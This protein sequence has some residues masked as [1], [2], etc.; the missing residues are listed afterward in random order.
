MTA[1]LPRPRVTGRYT[2][3][4]HG[5]ELRIYRRTVGLM[6]PAELR[7]EGAAQAAAGDTDRADVCAAAL[8]RL[9]A[10]VV[11]APRCHG[12]G[13]TETEPGIYERTE[14]TDG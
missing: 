5:A 9:T 11:D 13:W 10:L 12:D 14:V 8:A 3:A 2:D 7:A 1:V 4:A 6:T